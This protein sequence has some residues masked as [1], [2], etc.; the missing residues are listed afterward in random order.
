MNFYMIFFTLKTLKSASLGDMEAKEDIS[1]T[2]SGI[3]LHSGMCKLYL[4]QVIVI[5][6][7]HGA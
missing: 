5:I 3:I 6:V 4:M 7:Y 1:D 2:D